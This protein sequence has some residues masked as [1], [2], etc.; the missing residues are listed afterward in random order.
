MAT[1][2]RC[3]GWISTVAAPKETINF[4]RNHNY[5]LKFIFSFFWEG[6][7]GGIKCD[8]QLWHKYRKVRTVPSLTT[9]FVY[10]WINTGNR[11]STLVKVLWYKLKGRWFD[12]N[13]CKWIFHW[14]KILPIA[15]WPSASNRKEYQE[16]FLGVKS[17]LCVRL[18]T[19]PPSC[20]VVTKSG[21]LNF[22]Q[23]SGPLTPGL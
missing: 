4:K 9:I 22:L 2:F 12:P 16:H 17:G 18:T 23:P 13:W 5:L 15:L 11:G 21:N 20:A 19:L 8:I 14:H 1:L 7:G 10:V 6:R 3:P